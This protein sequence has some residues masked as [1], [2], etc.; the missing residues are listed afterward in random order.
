MTTFKQDLAATAGFVLATF[1][2]IESGDPNATSLAV[3]AAI[4]P[5]FIVFRHFAGDYK[6][7]KNEGI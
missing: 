3:C 2:L 1:F 7:H 4:M 6:T 5:A